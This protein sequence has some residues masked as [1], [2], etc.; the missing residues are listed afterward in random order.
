[1]N[2]NINR[3]K[4]EQDSRAIFHDLHV[5]QGRNKNIYDRLTN[6]LSTDYL[7]LPKDYFK[8]KICLDAGCGSNANATYNLL[9]MGA[10]MVHA[11]DLDESIFEI[12]PQLLK[13][14]KGHYKLN[15]GNV[16][17]IDYP[18]EHF[19]FVHCAGV[20]HHTADLFLGIKELGRVTKKGGVIYLETYGKGGLI[21]DIVSLLRKKYKKDNDFRLFVDNLTHKE[22]QQLFIVIKNKMIEKKDKM[23]EKIKEKVLFELV[24]EDLVLT[25]KDRIMSPVYLEHSYDEIKQFLEDIGFSNI[26]RLQRYPKFNNLRRFLAPLYSDYTSKWSKIL[27]GSNMPHILAQKN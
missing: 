22:I 20:L 4:L 1:M 17:N 25:I 8:D 5:K 26:K 15:V 6:L 2:M 11:F 27:Y 9:E 18:D 23:G 21:R 10:K 13:K 24:D 14:Y 16:L 7:G 12:A 19:D 3:K